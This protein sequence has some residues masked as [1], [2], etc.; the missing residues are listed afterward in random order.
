MV[1]GAL[2]LTQTY[3]YKNIPHG[4]VV[5]GQWTLVLGSMDL[6][7]WE[8]G[9]WC[10]RKFNKGLLRDGNASYPSTTDQFPLHLTMG[11]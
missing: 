1:Q 3:Y 2:I 9:P 8:H 6:G 11:Q 10:L 4:P 5:Y 7:A